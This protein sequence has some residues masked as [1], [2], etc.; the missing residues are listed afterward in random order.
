MTEVLDRAAADVLD[1]SDERDVYIN[2]I[3]QARRAGWLAGHEAGYDAGREAEATERD[4]EW[5]QIARPVARGGPAHAELQ[6][7]RW[8]VRGEQRD[9]ATFGLPH[10]GDFPGREVTA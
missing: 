3:T 8:T 2:R 1:C 5:D 10:P 7:R 9:R 4:A 6:R